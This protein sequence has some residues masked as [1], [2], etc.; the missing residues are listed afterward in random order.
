MASESFF[1]I[2][3]SD[4]L[5]LM[6]FSNLK[7]VSLLLLA[8]NKAP[9]EGKALKANSHKFYIIKVAFYKLS[10]TSDAK[11]TKTFILVQ[12]FRYQFFQKKI[13]I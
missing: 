6:Y 9:S 5:R 12:D 7:A 10:G 2:V 3:R 8:I 13:L 11:H 4:N 1:N